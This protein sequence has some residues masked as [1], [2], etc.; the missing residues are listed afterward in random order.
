MHPQLSS[1]EKSKELGG[2][3]QRR[4]NL[5][6]LASK[7]FLE[8]VAL[9]VRNSLGWGG[10]GAQGLGRRLL[11]REK[12]WVNSAKEERLLRKRRSLKLE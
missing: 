8:E 6:W 7:G 12:R 9:K 10:G 4:F 5:A 1:E 3:T 11:V 2:C